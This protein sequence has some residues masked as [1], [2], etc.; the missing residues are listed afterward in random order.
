MEN[1]S[2]KLLEKVESKISKI[3]QNE[4]ILISSKQTIELFEDALNKLKDF[5]SDYSFKDKEEEIKFFK[6]IK[7]R[8]LGLLLYHNKVYNIEVIR[9][10][11]SIESQKQYLKGELV[12]LRS[13]FEKHRELYQYQRTQGEFLD[14]YFFMRGQTQIPFGRDSFYFESDPAFS[15]TYDYKVSKMLAYDMLASYLNQEHDKL[16]VTEQSISSKLPTVKLSWTGKK[17]ELVELIYA[18]Q[19]AGLFNNGTANIKDVTEYF[20]TVFNVELK[21]Y[22]RT[23]SEIRNRKENRTSF[24]SKLIEAL[25]KRMDDTDSK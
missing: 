22:Y 23:Y 10:T 1:Y 9:P 12:R 20:E 25:T 8:F 17:A 19:E 7:P 11:E 24:L 14:E 6:K 18:L 13:F 21:D 5:I 15:T 4:N 3:P 16:D 2:K